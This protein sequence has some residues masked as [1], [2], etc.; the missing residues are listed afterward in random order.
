MKK[1]SL[2]KIK[3]AST[4]RLGEHNLNNKL[5]IVLKSRMIKQTKWHLIVLCHNNNEEAVFNLKAEVIN[6]SKSNET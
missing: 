3:R 6:E 1:G 4:V 2:I 5:A